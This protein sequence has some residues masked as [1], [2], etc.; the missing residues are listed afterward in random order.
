MTYTLFTDEEKAM[1]VEE[2]VPGGRMIGDRERK[3]RG[4]RGDEGEKKGR[5]GGEK[6]VRGRREKGVR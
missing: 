6:R 2:R 5:R 1:L 4:G 3:G